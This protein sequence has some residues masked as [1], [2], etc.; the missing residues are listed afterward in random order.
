[1]KE[2]YGIYA[3]E[4][5]YPIIGVTD[6]VARVIYKSYKKYKKEKDFFYEIS[7]NNKWELVPYY[8]NVVD[9]YRDWIIEKGKIP[10]LKGNRCWAF[11]EIEQY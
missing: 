11:S 10:G 2:M 6:N 5:D 7:I 4:R 9:F 1:M 8:N 3:I